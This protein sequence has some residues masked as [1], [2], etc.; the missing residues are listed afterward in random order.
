MTVNK[1]TVAST[2]AA[3]FLASSGSYAA[4]VNGG[5]KDMVIVDP[6]PLVN[7][8]GW[9][10]TG[11]L[12]VSKQEYEGK[13]NF[14]GEM[15]VYTTDDRGA[16]GCKGAESPCLIDGKW[17]S[18]PAGYNA[19]ADNTATPERRDIGLINWPGSVP[20]ELESDQNLDGALEISRVFRVG[21]GLV[22]EPYVGGSMPFGDS[23]TA[24]AYTYDAPVKLHDSLGGTPIGTMPSYGVSEVEKL[25][26]LSAGLKVGFTIDRFY[27]YVG[28]GANLGFFTSKG[29]NDVVGG[30]AI[31]P[32][33]NSFDQDDNVIGYELLLGG[34]Y[35]LTSRVLIGAEGIWKAW[36]GIEGG[37]SRK[38][39]FGSTTSG[40]YVKSGGK[41]EA[42][43]NEWAIKG[44]VSIKLS[45]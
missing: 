39:D 22:I 34:K 15:G 2:L 20:F 9:Y 17:Q 23:S 29:F 11:K 40:A 13:R 35:A 7:W 28:G 43:A 33:R 32:F 10:V 26:D 45:D 12:G 38:T 5:S 24:V 44:T 16:D 21:G 8:N 27:G 30:T 19:N 1:S 37:A 31:S 14:D 4:D 18:A 41:N 6:S 42:D 36:D 25:F 3:I